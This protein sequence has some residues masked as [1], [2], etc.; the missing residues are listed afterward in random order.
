MLAMGASGTRAEAV[1]GGQLVSLRGAIEHTSKPTATD[2]AVES[3][4]AIPSGP[5]H[6]ASGRPERG[7]RSTP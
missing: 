3:I 7:G 4:A 5:R 6:V 2:I 1:T